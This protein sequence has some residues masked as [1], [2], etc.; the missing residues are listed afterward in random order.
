MQSRSEENPFADPGV[1]SG[2]YGEEDNPF[3]NPRR[4]DST[5]DGSQKN[6]LLPSGGSTA[7]EDVNVRLPKN[8]YSDDG[9]YSNTHKLNINVTTG[10]TDLERREAE[11]LRRE[12]ELN[13]REAQ[14]ASNPSQQGVVKNWPSKC[15]PLARHDIKEDIAPA[16]QKHMRLMYFCCLATF[17]TLFWSWLC[18]FII[19]IGVGDS[20]VENGVGFIWASLYLGFGTTGAWRMWYM[21]IYNSLK[22]DAPKKALR[23][24]MFKLFFGI[25]II[26][27]AIA[28]IGMPK[29]G[30]A[31][32]MTA[33]NGWSASG[34]VG[35]LCFISALLW[36]ALGIASVALWKRSLTIAK[37]HGATDQQAKT[38]L[39]SQVMTASAQANVSSAVR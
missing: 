2:A 17:L 19:W 9:A 11:L 29:W 33:I 12:R 6:S 31:G 8:I 16:S 35:T 39:V 32:Y 18:T 34:V 13:E 36:T 22:V 21:R 24:W 4:K 27:C 5:G 20:E 14:L 30:M 3:H 28:A 38:E 1:M 15:Y 37:E 25:H 23:W 10:H 26:F 7:A